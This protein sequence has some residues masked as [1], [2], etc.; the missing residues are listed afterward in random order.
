MMSTQSQTQ[1]GYSSYGSY[2]YGGFLSVLTFVV[3]AIIL[4]YVVSGAIND[5]KCEVFLMFCCS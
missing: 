4:F 1:C 5:V 3:G 2:L